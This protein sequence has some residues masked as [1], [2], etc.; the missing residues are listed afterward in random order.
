MVHCLLRGGG[1]I[2]FSFFKSGFHSVHHIG[3]MPRFVRSKNCFFFLIILCILQNVR[4]IYYVYLFIII[5]LYFLS[6]LEE[7]NTFYNFFSCGP[8]KINIVVEFVKRRVTK[9]KNIKRHRY[10]MIKRSLQNFELI[11]CGVNWKKKIFLNRCFPKLKKK[12]KI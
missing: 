12:V 10:V 3:T 6:Q 9:W 7:K 4:I 8:Y 11:S 5:N 1:C 2:F